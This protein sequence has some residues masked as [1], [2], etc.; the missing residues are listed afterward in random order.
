MNSI[1][2][3]NSNNNVEKTFSGENLYHKKKINDSVDNNKNSG[4]PTGYKLK[5]YKYIE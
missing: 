2:R 5:N 4:I 3:N 1:G